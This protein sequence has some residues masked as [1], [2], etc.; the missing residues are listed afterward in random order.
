MRKWIIALMMIAVLTI[1]AFSIGWEVG[2]SAT[3]SQSGGSGR[4]GEEGGAKPIIGLH[5]GI[6]PLAILYASVDSLMLPSAAIEGMTGRF[7]PGFL[8]LIDAG[9]RL[10]LGPVV[11][12]VEAGVNNIYVYKQDELGEEGVNWGANMRL[13]LGLKFGWWGVTATGTVLFA[14]FQSMIDTFSKLG[15]DSNRN[16]ALEDI[17]D[18]LVPSLMAV[19]Y[20]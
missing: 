20:F 12:L 3:I 17:K 1:P 13:G 8:N 4:E 14:S 11:V 6:S 15:S 7:R 5:V 9:I 16:S 19:I 10:I 18:G 2:L